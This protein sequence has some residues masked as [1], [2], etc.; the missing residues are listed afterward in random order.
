MILTRFLFLAFISTASGFSEQAQLTRGR[1]YEALYSPSGKLTFSP[2]VIIPEPSDPTALLL[3]TAE[4]VKTSEKLRENGKIN[5]AFLSGTLSSLNRFVKEQEDARGSFPGPVPVIYCAFSGLNENDG[6]ETLSTL[7]EYGCSGIVTSVC[8]GNA[9]TSADDLKSNDE[10]WMKKALDC[11]VQPI[12]EV[13]LNMDNAWE[14]EDISSIIEVLTEKCGGE[15]G[16]ISIVLTLDAANESL[17]SDD[18][19]DADE[20]ETKLEKMWDN[21]PK[22]A[23]SFSKKTPILGSVRVD[24]LDSLTDYTAKLKSKGFT[25]AFLRADC[26]PGFR[27]NPDLDFVAGFWSAVISNLKSTK[28]KNFEFRTK[29]Q[30]EKDV[31][32][33]WMNYQK[34]VMESGALGE[35]SVKANVD[36]LNTEAGD[37]KGF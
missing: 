3:Q 15:N 11:G 9:I 20:L 33:E 22:F 2:E 28:S 16:P 26:V 37:Y 32:M 31:P 10:D 34:D 4:I 21:V 5:S 8:S 17:D 13:L 23:R 6:D 27:M 24:S 36:D 14:V 30:L 18:S 29:T 7:A 35:S 25:G 12:P 1:L 19:E